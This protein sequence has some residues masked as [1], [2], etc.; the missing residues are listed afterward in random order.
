M[1][2]DRWI[3]VSEPE[4]PTA[5]QFPRGPEGYSG[6]SLRRSEYTD[7]EAM[8][9]EVKDLLRCERDRERYYPLMWRRPIYM[10]DRL[11]VGRIDGIRVDGPLVMRDSGPCIRLSVRGTDV[12][13]ELAGYLHKSRVKIDG[14]KDPAPILPDHMEA[15]RV[16]LNEEV[17]ERNR[18]KGAAKA[19]ATRARNRAAARAA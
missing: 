17:T 9:T 2:S 16:A 11:I 18:A 13:A 12:Y 7:A 6:F 5:P 1:A 4:A 8:D 3:L 10:G 14:Y 15:R 19:A